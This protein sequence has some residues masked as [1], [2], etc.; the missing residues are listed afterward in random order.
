MRLLLIRHAQSSA[1]AERRIQGHLDVPLSE[2]G[3]RESALLA[4][5]LAQQA[6]DVLYT[7]PLRRARQTAEVV[8]AKLGLELIERPA[9]IERDV[10]ELAGLTREEIV[11]RFPHY[12]PQR[13]DV[14][15]EIDVPGFENDGAFRQRVLDELHELI[16]RHT[17]GTV[18]AVTHGG[19]IGAFCRETLAMP[20]SR[21]APFAIGNTSISTFDIRHSDLDEY[22]RPRIQ[23]VVLNDTCHLDGLRD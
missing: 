20:S 10:G 19:V 14:R 8:G 15:P 17:E 13:L 1:N 23:V 16:E 9:L 11:E 7:S 22:A 6:I 4:E 12:L 2:R 3:L 21:P 18:A 5:R